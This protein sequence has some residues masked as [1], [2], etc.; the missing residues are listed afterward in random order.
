MNQLVVAIALV[1][2]AAGSA[3]CRTV[4][5]ETPMERPNLEVPPPPPRTIEP[6]V[7]EPPQAEPVT[8]T[9]ATPATLPKPRPQTTTNKPEAKPEPPPEPVPT[10]PAPP[11]AT[12]PELRTPGMSSGPEAARQ[13]RATLDRTANLLRVTDYRTLSNERRSSYDTA[14]RF[15]EEG[16][17]ELRAANYV[18]ARELADKAERLAKELQGR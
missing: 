14:R 5:A 18:L 10:P 17:K 13:I 1:A 8:E 2:A 11:P 15:M 9:P 16:D 12:P 7:V 4:R 6:H 3:A